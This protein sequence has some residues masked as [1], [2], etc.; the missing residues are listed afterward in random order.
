MLQLLLYQFSGGIKNKII[1]PR[2]DPRMVD[3]VGEGAK[4]QA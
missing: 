4:E 3:K 1:E 2:L